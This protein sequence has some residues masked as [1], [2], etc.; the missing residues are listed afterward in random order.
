MS[1]SMRFGNDQVWLAAREEDTDGYPGL[2]EYRD[3]TVSA[4][5][6]EFRGEFTAVLTDH[7]VATFCRDLAAAVADAVPDGEHTVMLGEG[8]GLA[9]TVVVYRRQGAFS[10]AIAELTPHGAD[11]IPKLEMWL[12]L[13]PA[14]TLAEAHRMLATVSSRS[15]GSAT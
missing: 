14:A 1:R 12:Q 9:V 7:G 8:R 13:D 6:G 3:W 10:H 2:P 5:C 11:P 15:T 4:E